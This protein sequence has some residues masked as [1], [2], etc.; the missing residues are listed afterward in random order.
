MTRL[1]SGC[2]YHIV[3]LPLR[4]RSRIEAEQQQFQLDM[5]YFDL[6]TG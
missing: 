2:R 5:S 4:S 6:K 1:D 3:L